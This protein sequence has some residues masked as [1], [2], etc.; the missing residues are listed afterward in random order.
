MLTIVPYEPAHYDA[1]IHLLVHWGPDWNAS[2]PD[3]QNSIDA[4]LR[5][6][7]HIDLAFNEHGLVG[8]VQYGPRYRIGYEPYLEL[9]QLLVSENQR[10]TGIGAELVGHVENVARETGMKAVRLDS[11]V[12]RSRAHV[13]YERLGYSFYKISKFYAKNL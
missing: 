7:D 10:S 12:H 5:T 6:Q 8:Y 3:I 11:Q 1:F 2:H 4:V 9:I 13:F